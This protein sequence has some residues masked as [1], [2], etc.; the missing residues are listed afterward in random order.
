MDPI[1]GVL[2]SRF[3]GPDASVTPWSEARAELETAKTYWVAT[4]RRD[5]QRRPIAFEVRPAKAFGFGK[6]DSFSQTRWRWG[7]A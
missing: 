2:D 6:G 3:S 7:G 5:G 4:V 1:D